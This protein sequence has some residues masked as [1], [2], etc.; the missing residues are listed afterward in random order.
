MEQLDTA[1]W[2]STSG[3]PTLIDAARSLAP[4]IRRRSAE[5]EAARRLPADLARKI[6][7]R[8]LFRL[9]A[10]KSHGGFEMPPVDAMRVIE[11]VSQFDGSVGWCVMIAVVSSL[12]GG[13]LPPEGAKEIFGRD[14]LSI[15]GGALAPTGRAVAVEGGYRVSGKWNWGSGTQNCQWIVGTCFVS[16]ASDG[17]SGGAAAPEV[18]Q[19]FFSADQVEILDTWNVSGLCGTGSHDFQ[20]NDA[21][22]PN[23]R[24]L[25]IARPT[26]NTPLYRCPFSGLGAAAVSAVSMGIARRAIDEF[27]TLARD[28]IPTL[29]RRALAESA[30]VQAWVAEAEAA[31][32]SA[33]AYLFDTLDVIWRDAQSS[34]SSLAA[35][36]NLRLAAANA[37]WRS[38]DAADLMYSA[39]GGS[40][41][42]ATSPLQRC[43]RDAHVATQ[44]IAVNPTVYEN[45]GRLFL[46]D[47]PEPAGF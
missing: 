19:V 34:T 4:E 47:G 40:S 30:R 8:G 25:S 29:D 39:G 3:F 21:F 45:A 38:A 12:L 44:H 32:G 35:R 2:N 28:K 9:W 27:I 11:E 18:A 14:P 7:E 23:R 10:P 33:R 6:A 17:A 22:V 26:L 16:R 1:R 5:F 37:A 46:F 42:H 43:F 41:V 36:R 24:T 13:Y 20:T 15:V 31:L